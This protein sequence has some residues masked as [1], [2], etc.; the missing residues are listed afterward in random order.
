MAQIHSCHLGNYIVPKNTE[1][2]ICVDIGGNTG[3]FSLKYKF[4]LNRSIFMNHKENV[5]K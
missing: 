1:N 3:Q 5:M 4:F 2:G